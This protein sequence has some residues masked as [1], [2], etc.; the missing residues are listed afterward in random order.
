MLTVTPAALERLSRKLVYKKAAEG[1]ALRFVRARKCW[2]LKLD[3]PRPDDA[4]FTHEG[5]RVL[6]LDQAVAE[7]MAAMTLSVHSTEAG[8][9]LRLLK[10]QDTEG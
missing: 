1:A 5:R 9:R 4:T 3:R 7:A 8:P 6:V 10:N 2:R